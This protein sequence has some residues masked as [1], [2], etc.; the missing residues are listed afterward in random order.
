MKLKEEISQLVEELGEAIALHHTRIDWDLS[1]LKGR[2]TDEEHEKLLEGY[3]SEY[4]VSPEYMIVELAEQLY[5]RL[6]SHFV[7]KAAKERYERLVE[8]VY[9]YRHG[10]NEC[11]GHEE[12]EK[13]AFN[14]MMEVRKELLR[15]TGDSVYKI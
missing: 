7:I 9:I 12:D 15:L 4:K 8:Q 10:Y 3:Y 2:Y 13:R 14:E 5:P 6:H 11:T 1:F